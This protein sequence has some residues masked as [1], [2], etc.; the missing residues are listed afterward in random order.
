M[1]T[2]QTDRFGLI[3]VLTEMQVFRDQ[4]PTQVQCKQ[5]D[6]IDWVMCEMLLLKG[7]VLSDFR[8]YSET[9]TQ[10]CG[11]SLIQLLMQMHVFRGKIFPGGRF[12]AQL[13]I[14]AQSWQVCQV[15]QYFIQMLQCLDKM[16]SKLISFVHKSLPEQYHDDLVSHGVQILLI[17]FVQL[18]KSVRIDYK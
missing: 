7:D 4:I 17:A 1:S 6:Y 12:F 5:E 18:M 14:W 2:I 16:P 15:V 11:S 8:F 3:H 9:H 13:P 10:T